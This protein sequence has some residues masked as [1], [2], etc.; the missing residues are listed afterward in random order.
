MS[1]RF[2]LN[3][4]ASAQV[5]ITRVPASHNT[6]AHTR[7]E[8]KGERLFVNNGE[9][10]FED[11]GSPLKAHAS[12]EFMRQIGRVTATYTGPRGS[13]NRESG[14]YQIQD[15]E[16][17]IEPYSAGTVKDPYETYEVTL[18]GKSLDAVK[19]LLL[20]IIEGSIRPERSLHGPQG[21]T[22]LT[23][24]K[25]VIEEQGRTIFELTEQLARAQTVLDS[26][27]AVYSDYQR[28]VKEQRAVIGNTNK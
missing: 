16:A 15:A 18:T 4:V 24:N 22:P 27:S 3:S 2:Y 28:V 10:Y 6:S 7:A 17:T 8:L 12:S 14:F 20:A 1:V 9:Y 19:K 25:K 11:Y 5:S 23:I 13:V 21:G 26:F